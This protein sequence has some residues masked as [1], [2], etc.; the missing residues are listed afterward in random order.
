MTG[1]A[2]STQDALGALNALPDGERSPVF[3]APWE[4]EAFA[5]AVALQRKGVFTWDEWASTLGQAIKDARAAGD[6][7]TGA[8]YYSHWL[9]AVERIVQ[10]KGIADAATLNRYRD[11]WGRAAERTPHGEPIVLAP[12][13]MA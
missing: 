4:A 11:A 9:A 6:P 3:N 1:K 2:N 12:E 5:I 8:T 13:D 7:D 10:Q